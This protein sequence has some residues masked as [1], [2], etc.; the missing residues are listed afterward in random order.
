D[1]FDAQGFDKEGFDKDGFDAQGFDKEGF[2]KD[3]FDA[4]G[5]DKEG[6]GRN[7]FDSEGF[8]RQGYDV[9]GYDRQG[10]NHSGFD[11]KGYDKQG[12]DKEGFNRGGWDREGYDRQGVD[13]NGWDRDG[14]DKNGYDAQGYDRDGYNREGQS[15]EGYD[16][17]GY[18]K[19]GFN[20]HG[21]DRDGYDREG[22]NY[23]GYNRSGRDPWGYDKQ[24][25]GKD[26]YHWSGYNASGYDR[27]GRHWSENPYKDS[28]FDVTVVG[29]TNPFAQDREVI[30]SVEVE[31]DANGNVI[32]GRNLADTWKPTKPP[33]GE[34][35]HRTVEKY[36]AKPWD[37]E[38]PAPQ[39]VKPAVPTPKDSG[40]IGPE[41]PMNTLENHG[42]DQDA[43]TVPGGQDGS[44]MS[45]PEEDIPQS[46]W[47]GA[48]PEERF[49]GDQIPDTQPSDTFDYTDPETGVTSSF[50]YES[51]YTGPRHGERQ[52]L[53][54]AG[55]GQPYEVEFNAVTG[56]WVNTESGNEFD[57]SRFES[58]QRDIAEDK[59]RAAIDLEKMAAR[60]D[61][62]SKAID[63]NLED[64][65]QLEQMQKAADKYGIGTPGGPGDVDKAI[66]GLKDD[67]L[68][69]K[70]VNKDRMEQL[71]KIIGNRIEGRSAGDSGFRKEEDWIDTMG[72]AL[73]ANL[74]TAKEVV[75]GEKADGSISWKGMAAKLII[76]AATGGVPG[77]IM[78]VGLTAAEALSHIKD[79]IDKG[80]SDFRAVSRAMG[81]YVLGEQMGWLAGK[82]M[83][84][85][86]KSMLERFPA[87]TNKAADFLETALLK[88]SAL[89]QQLSR[90]LGL[91]SKESAE[92]ALNQI[93]R[94]LV[95]IGGDQAAGRFIKQ[96]SGKQGV[97]AGGRAAATGVRTASNTTQA[98]SKT[99]QAAGK[100]T[101]AAGK[102]TQ[103][104]SK[105]TQAAGK[106]TQAAGKSADAIKTS[107][108][109]VVTADTPGL[110]IDKS[111]F[112]E[113]GLPP[114][115]RGM[116]VRDQKA[117]RSVCD[118]YGVKAHMRPTNPDS[119]AWLE[120]GR[121]HPK[122][123]MIKSK[124]INQ[125]DVEL[126]YPKEN[127][128]TV[129]CRRPDP[130]PATKPAAMTDAHWTNLQK[131]HGQRMTE[132]TDQ[133]A[134][135]QHL[136]KKGII[137]WDQKTGI[138][139]NKQTMKPYCGDHDT[140]AIVDAV[141]GKPVSPRMNEQINRE[142]QS[143]GAT[144]HPEHVG[145]DYSGLSNQVPD[146]AAP[147]AQAPR[148]IAEAID[149]KILSGH[150]DGG[151]ALNT[152]DPLRGEEGG[153]TTN[154][155]QGGVRE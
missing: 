9:N 27:S 16:A 34:P 8:D 136:E 140:F 42:I 3:G 128:G 30:A 73:E 72:Y 155:W 57:P 92:S 74:A 103:A 21:Y 7:G 115:L 81:T 47:P 59:R 4:Q 146:G 94:R 147:G 118:K 32:G 145:W 98:A 18:D 1:G 78:N 133:A 84:A 111:S 22:F 83:G 13:S 35:Y 91:I 90:K 100:T 104:A 149:R 51:G 138:I 20:E 14:Y 80:G 106:T 126:G 53:V 67:M 39:P 5:F 12:F 23:E 96:A 64:W 139:Y 56:K 121:A 99:T 43:P 37:D 24:G 143:L 125:L 116:P 44:G 124:T 33:L 151:E 77:K 19:K 49:P 93:N 82:G 117:I 119:R 86:N 28:P 54:G 97:K 61:A 68:A 62:T 45:I 150:G 112:K 69:G 137:V 11:A 70:E 105:T 141:N 108:G 88:G 153:W 120:T 17:D 135:L 48:E 142:L 107:R 130:L 2:D 75:T 89:N 46:D 38:I 15:Q 154:W 65:R 25:Y 129:G 144:Q 79:E 102:T 50:E 110:K 40:V 132:F 152:F 31:L 123:E 148:E 127:I 41:D 131:R 10:F 101:Q 63:K 29:N 109:P 26:G 114:D 36:G 58:W 95:D 52:V 76:T 122:P 85:L 71:R 60:E 87:F 66:Q 55:D 113:A 6:F 134:K